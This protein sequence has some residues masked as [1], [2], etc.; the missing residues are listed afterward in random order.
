[1]VLGILC[2]PH[3]AV[4]H[5]VGMFYW[6]SNHAIPSANWSAS[7]KI[8]ASLCVVCQVHGRIG[9]FVCLQGKGTE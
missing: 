4:A 7:S 2:S 9:T 1:M 8:E 6:Y 5:C 3:L